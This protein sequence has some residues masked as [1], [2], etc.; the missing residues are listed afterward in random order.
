MSERIAITFVP[1]MR[2]IMTTLE[3]YYENK[4]KAAGFS[5]D[6]ALSISFVMFL[7]MTN[8]CLIVIDV[9]RRMQHV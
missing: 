4:G 3:R 8:C 7:V 5:W 1:G 9:W 6:G 2:P